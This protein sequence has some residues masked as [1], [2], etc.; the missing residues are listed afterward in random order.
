MLINAVNNMELICYHGTIEKCGDKILK[1]NEYIWDE[2][3]NHWLGDGIYFYDDLYLARVW[4][5]EQCK[6]GE[7]PVVLENLIVCKDEKF[8]DLTKAEQKEKFRLDFMDFIAQLK[9]DGYSLGDEVTLDKKVN[10]M[11]YNYVKT[12][13]NYDVIKNTFC[14]NKTRYSESNELTQKINMQYNAY[15]GYNFFETQI[16]ATNNSVVKNIKYVLQE[17]DI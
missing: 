12:N 11:Y 16:C 13:C 6:S 7:N 15:S 14:K 5:K 8:L 17:E 4:A 10:S 3:R 2:N 9:E 1:D